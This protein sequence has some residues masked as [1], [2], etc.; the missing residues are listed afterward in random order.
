MQPVERDEATTEE[1]TKYNRQT[2]YIFFDFECT[3][4]KRLECEKGYLSG[5]NN[6]CVNCKKSWCGSMEHR[7]NLCVAHKVCSLCM[8]HDFTASS[9]CSNCVPYERVFSGVDTTEKF[10]KWLFTAQNKG[11]TVLCHNFKGYDSYPIMKFLYGNA[12]L[13]EVITT[14]SKYMSI[15]VPLFNIRFIDSLNFIPMA[16]ADMP[17]AFGETELAKGYFPHLFN[18]TENQ[19]SELDHLPDIKY[20]NPDSMKPEARQTFCT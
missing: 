4:D 1:K 20:Y 9:E 5:V 2:K 12:I 6:T 11:A 14:G 15:V 18:T 10:C 3:L 13:L 7:P 8:C 16:L 19:L 17:K